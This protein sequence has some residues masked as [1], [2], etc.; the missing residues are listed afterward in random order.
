MKKQSKG[1]HFSSDAEVMAAAAI[2][3]EGQISE[4]F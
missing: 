3:L 4:F 1:S 2:W